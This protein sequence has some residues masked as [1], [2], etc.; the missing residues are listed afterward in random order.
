MIL[1]SIF[2]KHIHKV[3]F[4][5]R[6]DDFTQALL[7]TNIM[8][9]AMVVVCFLTYSASPLKVFKSFQKWWDTWPLILPG[10]D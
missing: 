9:A 3:K 5:P 7:V 4:Y 1:T 2:R 8:S 10:L 6:G